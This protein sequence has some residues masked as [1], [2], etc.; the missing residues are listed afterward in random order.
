MRPRISKI[1]IVAST[2]PAIHS[3][4]C[5]INGRRNSIQK[6][7]MVGERVGRRAHAVLECSEVSNSRIKDT[8]TFRAITNSGRIQDKLISKM[9][10]KIK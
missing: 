8:G 5:A 4:I 10:H 2:N 1:A 3:K 7:V 6:P 9:C